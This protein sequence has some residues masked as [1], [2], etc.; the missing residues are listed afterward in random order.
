MDLIS[1]EN[2]HVRYDPTRSLVAI[3]GILRLNGMSEYEPITAVLR[4]ALAQNEILTIDL[5]E[6][7]FLNSSG[8][9][10]LSK[11][12]IEARAHEGGSLTVLGSTA[13]AWQGK[14]LVNL[15]RLLPT[16]KLDFQ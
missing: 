13:V 5:T 1:G 6:L 15:K 11:F 14:S 7:E 10:M 9:A 8:I 2:Y 16:L 4:Q 12:V 3:S